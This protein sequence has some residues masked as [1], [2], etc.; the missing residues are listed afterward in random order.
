MKRTQI[1]L[2]EETY[3]ALRRQ[4]YKTDRS[5]SSLIRE[6]LAKTLRP[7]KKRR[8]TLKQFS[9]VAIGRSRQGELAPVSDHHDEALLEAWERS[10]KR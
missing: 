3:A 4:A 9:F 6:V 5:M 8:R 7:S 10:R 1:Q 2:D